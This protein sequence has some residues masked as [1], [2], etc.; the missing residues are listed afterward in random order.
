MVGVQEILDIAVKC[1]T[2][3][4]V[5]AVA[6]CV[7]WSEATGVPLKMPKKVAKPC[8]RRCR[9]RRQ[10]RVNWRRMVECNSDTRMMHC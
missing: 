9:R 2:A 3:I 5:A 10:E 7:A 8:K 4:A 1:D 6:A